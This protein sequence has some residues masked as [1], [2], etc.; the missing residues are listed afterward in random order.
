MLH[1]YT[2]GSCIGNPGPGGWAAAC[3]T[4]FTI[5]GG[6]KRSTNNIM[7]MTAVLNALKKCLE[8]NEI[9]VVIYTDSNYVKMGITTWIKNWKINGWKNAQG[10]P[11][12]NKE[13]W[14]AID[15]LVKDMNVEWKW[16]KAHNGEP[17]NELVDTLAR[18]C[19]TNA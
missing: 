16:V 18:E 6:V 12:A 3:D 9:N 19:A 10:K 7:E 5:K 8:L 13:L 1:V 2:D 11:V 17:M 15:T 4:I 14:V